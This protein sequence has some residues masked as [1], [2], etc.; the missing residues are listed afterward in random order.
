MQTGSWLFVTDIATITSKWGRQLMKQDLVCSA[1]IVG[2]V[3]I[4]KQTDKLAKLAAI[5]ILLDE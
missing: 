4:R 5:N 1:P 3:N 2:V